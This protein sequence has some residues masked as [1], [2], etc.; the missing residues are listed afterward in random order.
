VE[1][2]RSRRRW[3]TNPSLL[4]HCV[5][6]RRK[7]ITGRDR[8]SRRH[9]TNPWCPPHPLWTDWPLATA[10]LLSRRRTDLAVPG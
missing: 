5:H 2:E 8:S 1:E 7:N 6:S 4:P 10:R 9:W 3:A